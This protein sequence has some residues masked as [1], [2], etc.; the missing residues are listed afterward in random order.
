MFETTNQSSIYWPKIGGSGIFFPPEPVLGLGIP[1]AR[2]ELP[3][4]SSLDMFQ[5]IQI[6]DVA[7][8]LKFGQVKM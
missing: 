7:I 8:A 2:L 1:G 6:A 4:E 3:S 5:T